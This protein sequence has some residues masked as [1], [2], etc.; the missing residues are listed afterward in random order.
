MR[1]PEDFPCGLA[2]PVKLLHAD[3]VLMRRY[4]KD[5]VGG[6]VHYRFDGIDMFGSEP[7]YYLRTGRGI[8][9]ED[10]AADPFL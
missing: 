3:D 6:G 5:A 2:H 7:L 4:L 8:V 9:R 1:G 10:I